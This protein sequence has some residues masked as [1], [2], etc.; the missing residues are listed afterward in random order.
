MSNNLE[1]VSVSY[2][3]MP[4]S[5]TLFFP[6]VLYLFLLL[7]LR[8]S[9]VSFSFSLTSFRSSLLACLLG[10]LYSLLPSPFYSI[11]PSILSSFLAPLPSFSFILLFLASF[12]TYLLTSFLIIFKFH[13][14][15]PLLPDFSLSSYLSSFVFFYL[16]IHPSSPSF[17]P[18]FFSI[19]NH[20]LLL[21]HLL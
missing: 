10:Y 6:F 18:P 4:S 9:F 21:F 2:P 15:L 20:S 19:F 11:F 16:F 7:L 12:L 5:L 17:P 13:W 8:F 3:F 14:F 1:G